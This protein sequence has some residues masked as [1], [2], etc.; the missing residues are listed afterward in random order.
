MRRDVVRIASLTRAAASLREGLEETLTV[1]S[2]GLTGAL[3]RTL[4]CTNPI[5]NLNGSTFNDSL[6]G[7]TGANTIWGGGSGNDTLNGGAGND[8]LL[9]DYSRGEA[10]PGSGVTF[11]GSTGLQ[12]MIAPRKAPG[13]LT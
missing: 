12:P 4:R 10:L 11:A 7:N 1:L 6:R 8:T 5:E 2:L 13:V 9:L 3:Y